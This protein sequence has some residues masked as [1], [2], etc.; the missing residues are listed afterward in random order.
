MC[1]S[2]ILLVDAGETQQRTVL[3]SYLQE[4]QTPQLWISLCYVDGSFSSAYFR[5]LGTMPL[6]LS[7]CGSA[8][9]FTPQHMISSTVPERAKK[10]LTGCVSFYT[11]SQRTLT[12]ECWKV[13]LDGGKSINPGVLSFF[14]WLFTLIR[15]KNRIPPTPLVLVCRFPGGPFVL[16]PWSPGPSG[17]LVLWSLG[18][19]VLWFGPSSWSSGPWVCTFEANAFKVI[20]KTGHTS[21]EAP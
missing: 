13:F 3:P 16:V 20:W 7:W 1:V 17:P 11:Q 12:N 18:P 2:H 10:N 19:L 21:C 14:C 8:T 4:D 9:T 6:F 15:I 5:D